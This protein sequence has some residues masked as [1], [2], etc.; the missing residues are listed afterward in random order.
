MKN[1]WGSGGIAPRIRDLGSRWRWVVKFTTRPLYPQGRSLCYALYR[2]LG[3]PQSRLLTVPRLA[4]H[5][6]CY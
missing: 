6:P 5:A 4:Q 2:R 3:G 1:Y